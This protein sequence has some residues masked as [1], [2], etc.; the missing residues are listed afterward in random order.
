MKHKKIYVAL[1]A[2][3]GLMATGCPSLCSPLPGSDGDT[4]CDRSG[5]KLGELS[6]SD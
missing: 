4:A 1:F 2:T 3:L 6:R 5:A